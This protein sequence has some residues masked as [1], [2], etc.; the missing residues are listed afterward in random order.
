MGHTCS[1][2]NLNLNMNG[3]FVNSGILTS[4]ELANEQTVDPPPPFSSL[5]VQSSTRGRGR[6]NYFET[7][8]AEA[9]SR[10]DST[11][12]REP[13]CNVAIYIHLGGRRLLKLQSSR[14]IEWVRE[15]I[16]K[17]HFHCLGTEFI[18]VQ[19]LHEEYV[20][21]PFETIQQL[22]TRYKDSQDVLALWATKVLDI[23]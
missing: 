23:A 17:S 14:T 21:Y 16:L 7:K 13:L 3:N 6:D 22:H 10:L 4:Q 11:S 19:V 20:C 5:V 9:E 1:K 8:V 15:R 12:E 2:K 18:Q